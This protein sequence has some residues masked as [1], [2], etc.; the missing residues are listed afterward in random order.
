MK[1]KG[2]ALAILMSLVMVFAMM[3]MM[4]G[5][6]YADSEVVDAG[7]KYTLHDNG[8]ATVSGHTDALQDS[9]II[10][11]K[12]KSGDVDYAVTSIGE[13]AFSWYKSLVS[14][15]IPASVTSIGGS[16]FFLCS[17]LGMVTFEEESKLE[18]IGGSAFR[19]TGI[20]S[21]TIPASVTSIGGSAFLNCSNLGTV[22]FAEGGK[23][24]SIGGSAFRAT[25]LTSIMIPDAFK[26]ASFCKYY[27]F[28][29]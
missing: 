11:D 14:I 15:T 26:L 16:A 3:P 10:P 28:K 23:L 2:T 9:V 19:G 6:A 13:D 8:E 1:M 20:T 27:R 18:S 24:E 22:A 29:V 17:N 4:A 7:I 12:I 25:G 5:A 21:I